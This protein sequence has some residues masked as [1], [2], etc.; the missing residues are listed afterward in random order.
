M[1]SV[2]YSDF[3]WLRGLDNDVDAGFLP[4]CRL[5]AELEIYPD[6]NVLFERKS[7]WTFIFSYL[8]TQEAGVVQIIIQSLLLSSHY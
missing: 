3:Q 7:P 1:L 2:A 8:L 5:G 4:R 6:V